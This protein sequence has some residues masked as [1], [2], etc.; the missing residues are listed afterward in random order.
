M[1]QG[2]ATAE[3]LSSGVIPERFQ[4][5]L[6]NTGEPIAPG[7]LLTLWRR[8]KITDARLE[9][10]LRQSRVRN[11]WFPELQELGIQWPSWSEFLDAYL[12]G[13][14]DEGEARRLFQRAGGD[15][16][17]FDLLF[18]TRGQ[19]PTPNQALDLLNRGIIGE[20]GR[21]REAVTY[22]QA[23][24]EGPWRNKWMDPFLALREY[25][26]PPRSVRP[27]VAS[28]AWSKDRGIEE[29]AK[30]GV[31]E[32]T[33]RAIIE[34]AT[35]DKLRPERDLAKS[36]VIAAYRDGLMDAGRTMASL[37][38]LGY[39]TDEADLLIA[40]ADHAWEAAYRNAAVNRIR[41]LYVG[42][43]ITEEEA[44]SAI[45][46]LG[47]GGAAGSKY[48]A[49]WDIERTLPRADLTESQVRAAAKAGI[50]DQAYYRTWLG[51][52]GYAPDEVEILARL[53]LGA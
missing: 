44:A 3:A 33:A 47:V 29:L 14:V 46:A 13:Q 52:H 10:A 8:G 35:A 43:K 31:P 23:F 12:E 51:D 34:E 16:E 2:P 38:A 5:L 37:E 17:L 25:V 4:V 21:G 7:E 1:D 40:L 36:E 50:V 18:A 26:V 48:L 15:P 22:E 19:A 11:E 6:D 30:S 42:A 24:L 53:Y 27:M 20:R 49:L 39:S 41:G 9:Q 45:A 28:G 32:D